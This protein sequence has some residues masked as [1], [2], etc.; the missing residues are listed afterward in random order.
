M[1]LKTT[2]STIN[3]AG[4]KATIGKVSDM[5]IDIATGAAGIIGIAGLMDYVVNEGGAQIKS[6]RYTE[7]QKRN[8]RKRDEYRKRMYRTPQELYG[9]KTGHT[10]TWGGNKY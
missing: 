1:S 9:Y 6:N 5:G 7:I 10:N 3:K 8:N 2:L 4:W